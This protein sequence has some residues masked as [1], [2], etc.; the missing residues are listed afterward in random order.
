V[1]PADLATATLLA[2][3]A[4]KERDRPFDSETDPSTV[5]IT[6]VTVVEGRLQ[7]AIQRRLRDAMLDSELKQWRFS[8]GICHT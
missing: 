2:G 4:C 1:G 8:E 3:A 5:T 7:D 6:A